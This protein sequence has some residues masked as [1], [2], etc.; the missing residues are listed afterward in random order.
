GMTVAIFKDCSADSCFFG[1][2]GIIF[3]DCVSV[4]CFSGRT[5]II[6]K[7]SSADSR[8]FG[9][10]VT[11]FVHPSLVVQRSTLSSK[12]SSHSD[13]QLLSC[14]CVYDDKIMVRYEMEIH[15]V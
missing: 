11:I 14:L 12:N 13:Y 9:N 15:T 1:N 6:F 5:V 7:D 10:A 4:S 2:A 3:I 8:F